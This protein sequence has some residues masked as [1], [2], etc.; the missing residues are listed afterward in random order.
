L[1]AVEHANVK[2]Q[3][4][5]SILYLR[6]CPCIYV[7]ATHVDTI[8]CG[9]LLDME[10]VY[11]TLEKRKQTGIPTIVRILFDK[12]NGDENL[13][14]KNV[15]MFKRVFLSFFCN[16]RERWR[17]K[18]VNVED[19]MEDVNRKTHIVSSNS[20]SEAELCSRF[21]SSPLC[22]SQQPSTKTTYLSGSS[23]TSSTSR[24]LH[25]MGLHWSTVLL[26]LLAFSINYSEAL[27]N[28]VGKSNTIQNILLL[29]S[30][31]YYL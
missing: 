31:H 26:V 9:F 19:K 16:R 24:R 23:R 1:L 28:V 21:S 20:S 30:S 11:D 3:I 7:T 5:E 17:R 8:S 14:N 25:F 2:L 10:K 22:S 27:G 18:N 13:S 29:F 4:M 15:Q 12:A 6:T